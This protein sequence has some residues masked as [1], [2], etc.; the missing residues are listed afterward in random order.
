MK[1]KNT[2]PEKDWQ[3]TH[4][5]I[6]WRELRKRILVMGLTVAMVANTVDLSAL[7][8]SAKTDE[9]ETGKTTIVSF[10]ELSKDITEQTLP[11]GA[12]ESDIKFPTS[13]TVTVEKTTHADE[14]EADDEE[15]ASETGDT[16]KDDAQKD[17]SNGDTASSDDKK[18]TESSDEKDGDS[19]NADASDKSG[20]SD[21]GNADTK[22]SDTSKDSGNSDKSNNPNGSSSSDT[23]D[24]QAR[25]DLPSAFGALIG[26][27][28]D[29]LLPHKLIVYAAEKDDA[30]DT[31]ATSDGADNAKKTDTASTSDNADS[32]KTTGSAD[33]AASSDTETTTEK[34]RL[35]NIKWEL[36]VEE[37]DAE[38]FDS[39]EASNGFCYAYTPVLPDED[40]D[41][42]Q[43]VLGKDL[44]LPTIYVLV[45]EYGI[46]LLAGSGT[47]QITETNADGTKAPYTA[48]DLATWI[49][50]HGSANLEKVSIKLLNDDASITSALTIGTGLAKEIELDLNGHTLTLQGD[51]ARLYFKRANITITSSG[52]NEGTITGNYQYG[53][54]RLKGDG[55]ITVDSVLKIEHVTIKNAGTGSTVAMWGGATC[56]IDEA[57]ISGS[58][59]SQE[60]VITIC[61]SNACTIT[62]T[63]VT[64]NVASGYGA[65]MFMDSCSDCT[66][67]DGAVIKNENSGG[68]CV[69]VNGNYNVKITVEKDA[70]LTA[71]TGSGT[72]MNTSYGKVAVVIEGGTFNGRLFLPD[73]SQITGGTFV[74]ASGCAIEANGSN[75]TLQDLLKV[76]YTLQYEDGTYANLTAK[77]TDK[78]KKVTAVKSP[79]YFT[80]HPTI[81]SGA[82]TVM[83][84]YTAAEAPELTVEA[85]SGSAGSDSISY[86][87]YADETINGTTKNKVEQTGQGA[88]SATYKIPTGLL[89]GT[90]Q[91][92]CVATC[93]EYTAT[94]QKAA[95]TVEE[96]VA[97][98]TVGGNTTRYATLTK[99]FDAVKATVNAADADADLEITLKILKNISET[100]SE[101]KIDGG[102]KNVNFCMDLN[103]CTVTGKGLY[104]IG[105]GVK[106]VFKDAGTGQ[107][108][109]LNAPVSIRNKAKL[110]VENGNYTKNLRFS[111][112]ATGELKGGYYSQSIYIGNANS[113]NTGIS[114]TITG[115][116]YKGSEV[117][118][119]GGA[120][121]SV[122]GADTKIDTLQIDHSKK[123]RAEV[124]L[125]GGEYKIITLVAFPGSNDD[126]LDE[127]QRYAIADT[128]AE[129]Y[130]FYSAGIK[131]DISRT[132]KT[133]NNVKV[134]PAD[135]PED[136]SL[137]VVKFQIEKND[138]KTKTKY[139]LTWD[140]AMSCLE[141]TES[142]LNNLQEYTTWKKL[143]ILLLKDAEAT[144]GYALANKADLPAEIT[145]RSEGNEPH[146]LTGRVNQ[147]FKTGEQD[148][149]IENINVVGNISFPGDTAVLR[150]GGGVAGLKNVM[151]PSGKAEIVIEKGAEIPATF[152]GDDQS[153]LDVSIYCNH[154]S[155]GDIASRIEQGASAF[156]VWF[157][158]E[159][160]GITLPTDG[161]NVTN[162]TQ[163][164]G[165]TYGLY[166]NGG[167]TDQK[168]KVTGEVCS[169]EPYGGNAVT[170][171][172]T[173]LSFTMPSS[174]VTLKAHTKDDH[175]YCS[176]C[177]R[178]DLAEAYKKSRLI[179]EGLEGRIYDGYPQVMTG[180]TLKTA[181]GDVKLTGPKYKSGKELAQDSTG[182]A[183]ADI[184][185]AD[186]TVVY[187][188]NIKCNENKESTDA[189]TAIITGR[190]AYYG[191]VAF[192]F[193]IGQGEMQAA[194]ATAT[195]AE[196]DG[197]AHTA[198]TDSDAINV[199]LKADKYD[200]N[201]H[202]PVTDGYIAP[203]TGKTLAK[204]GFDS[205]YVD[206]FPLKISCKL[207]DGKGYDNA[208]EYTVTNAGSYPFTIM[209]MAEN[210]SCPSVEIPLTAKIT[211]R[212]LSK[213]SIP[214]TPLSGCAY[215]TGK[216]YSFDDLDWEATDLKK[217]LTDSGV[218]GADGGSYVLV[219]D[220]DF[221]VTEEDATGPATGAKPAKLN[222]TG[223]G[224][225]TGNAAIRFEI[226]YA[227]TLAQTLVSGTDKWY[228]ADVPVSFAIDNQND[229]SQILYRNS[230]AA[231]SDSCLNGSVEIYESLEAAVAGENPGYTFTQEGKNTVTLYGK[232]TAK[233]CLS[234]PVEVTICIDK[235]APTWADKDGVADGYGIQIK[236]NW[237]RSLLN[238]I[239][240]GYLYN[241]ATL[242]I[243]IQANDKKADVA[244]VSG[245]SRY[246]Y[247]VEKVSD[248]ALASVKTKDELDALAAGGKFSEAAAG[249][250]T[251]LTSSDGA[252][253]SG[254]LSSEGNYV[255][256]AYAVDGA[257]NQ[258]DYICT[259]GIVVDAQAPVVKIADPKKE[260]GTLKDTEA[261]LKVNLSEDATL[262][263]FFVSEGVF[264]GVTGYTYDDCKRD[265][266]NYMKGE[267]KYPQFAVENDGKW[268]PRN[269]WNFKPDENLYCGQW[270]VRT[271]GLKY[272][273]ANQNFVA[274]WT[275]SIFKTTGTKGDNK[276]EIGN[277][278]KP[279]VYF[280]LY[281]S[282][283]TAVWIAAIDKAGNITALTKPAIEFTTTKTT[284][285]VKTAPVLSGTYGN[286]VS[287]MFAKA[288]MT[289]A[290]VTA[291][292]NSDTKIEGTWTLASEDADKLPTVGTSEK[293]TLVFTPTG[294][295]ADTYDSVTCEVIP[296]VSKKQITVVIADKEKFYGET[297]PALTWSL[298][299]GDAYQD[300]VLVADDTEEALV[301]SLSTTAKDNSDV[302]TYAITGSSDSANYEVSFIGNGS[303]GKSGILTVKQA[304][305]SFTTELS[306]SDYTYAKDE[307]P[308]PNATAKFGTVTYKYATAASDGTAYK[309]PSDASAYTDA[310]PVN[311]GIYAVKAYI[312]ETENYAGLASDPVVFT[313]NKAASPNIGDEEKSYSYV[314][315]S[316]DKAISVD[317]AGKLPTDRGTTAYALTNTYNEQLLSDVAVDQD[318]KL[319]YKVKEADESQVGATA[320]ITVTASMLNY[321]DAVY[322]MTIKITDKKLVTLKSG[323]TVSVNGSNALTYGDKLSKLGFSD[324]TFVEADTDTEVKGTLKWADPDCIPTAGTTQAG[325][326]F[327][328]DDSKYYEDLT[329]TAA[330][331]VARATPAVVTVPTV[332]E[333]VYN[334]AVALADSDMTGGSV[335]GADGNSL[336][337]TWSFTG[338]NIIPTVNNKGYQAV[339]TPDDADNYNTVTRT[340]TV[341]VTKATPVI[342]Q[343][344]TAGAL[345][346]GQKLSDSTLTGGKAAYQTADGTEITGA[347]AWKNSSIK[348]TA[349]DSGKTEYDV[350]F[351]PSDTANYNAVGIK[352][353]LTVNK[354][355][356]APNMPE[357]TMAPAHSTKKVGDITLPDGWNW[358]E[359]DK[360]TALADGVAVTANAIYTG[361]DKGNYETESVSITITRSECDHTHTEIRNQREATCKEKGYTGDT[362]CKDC[363]EKLAAG[364]TIEKKPHK[365]G[366]P[367][368]CV[369][370]AVCSVCSETFG[371]VDATNHVHTTVKNRKEATCTQTGYAGDT[372]CTDCDKLLSTGKELAALGHDYK[373]TVTKQPTTTEEGIRT[374]TCTR[375]NSSYTESIAKLPEEKHTHN[376][377]GSITKEATCTEAGVRTYTCS[378]GNSYT[379]NIPATGHSYVS[380][381]TKAA[382][383]TEEGIMTYTCSKCGHSYT[384]PIAKIKSDDSNKDNGS[385]NQK[386]QSGTDNGNQ[387]QKP[388]PDTDNGKE[389]E[390]SIKPY[391]KDDSGKE[392][393]DVI[394]PQLEEAKSGDTVTVVMNGTTVV[395]K[396]IIDSIKGKDTTL[397]LDMGNG[398]S[399]KIY[400]KDITDAAGDI[401]FDVTVGADAGK[402]IP[403]DVINNVT[404]EHSSL[405]L[406]LAY[407]GEFGF[408]ATLTVNMESKNAGLY[409]NL[410]YYNEQT[411]ELEFI[412]A[413]Q[414]DPDGNVE[415]VFTHASDYTI[416]VDARIMSDNAQADNK[417]DESIPAP[418]TD[419]STSKYAWN[420]TIIIIIGICIIL[421]VFGAVFYVRKK[422]G[423]EEE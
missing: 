80:T 343:K 301:I 376:Y 256:Y 296:E 68:Y 57:N 377:T 367:A 214:P 162:I 289:K 366:T 396:D 304:A 93:G 333:R 79:L 133:L 196:Y 11:I 9:S 331:T 246:Y 404:G 77:Y 20:T 258:S 300:N 285:Y 221:T 124:T 390:D 195:A 270:E 313:I 393:W 399:W 339:F 268:A 166:S 106:A 317:I 69:K 122:S 98:V 292:L 281:P 395:P 88:T 298:A 40:G 163:R 316:D 105:E 29:A 206:K 26:Q 340:I 344:P 63:K 412:S 65:I 361:T 369:S 253:I 332:A 375:C 192:K 353:S 50:G 66:I 348:P 82:E 286:T 70:T 49:G 95:F 150:L 283:K 351:T 108:G 383:T 48:Q 39:S 144:R 309:A 107:N 227:F 237:F 336:A 103:G 67:G 306:C 125:S 161:E 18:D 148:V 299:S 364:T 421:I 4:E 379:E 156:K 5:K 262:M 418:K 238:T 382:T 96:G 419:D 32:V 85:V 200:A 212:D 99:A 356:K 28:A 81:A 405:N 176:N 260:D 181:N 276:I 209:V 55:L 406:T 130:A 60:G 109:T 169:Y 160:G 115:G 345:T 180:I 211:P 84:N 203:C 47:V 415:L 365:V 184:T 229:A 416:V 330:I 165:A 123:L 121:L 139:F 204:D 3:Q 328:P 398:L 14:K 205:E 334:P 387:N 112:G 129:G 17:D 126:L 72:I 302:G 346:Y 114:C 56:T 319:T 385:Q 171:K 44:E 131:T 177:K 409:A 89:A 216:P 315:G 187:E 263:W 8:V 104:I 392:G 373:A 267:P 1:K 355:A 266:E 275:P 182:S 371:E 59:G 58:N 87:W 94:S 154:D 272:S 312:A 197:K 350:T 347:F 308:E 288:D 335:T 6:R 320:T 255:V 159:L 158:I 352:L 338:K 207:A 34:I 142:N 167:T 170:I 101:W 198:L 12:L 178:T 282:K 75:K 273:N 243:K 213:L 411:G 35:K 287:A 76:G 408:T 388:Q 422:S 38:E 368:T 173:D 230:K 378:C 349:A 220:T 140:A 249:T 149:T 22:D 251:I 322:T 294:S 314:A 73:N 248:T 54:N 51:N 337:G 153:N 78:K 117:C 417:S 225:Y 325:W 235:S 36:N 239:S 222:L 143:E 271:E 274:S 175:G 119:Y 342:A 380:K 210:N 202:I 168:I 21:N 307:T 64:G 226:P 90:Y 372:Y 329:G 228:R 189:P 2:M 136:V 394:K 245:I 401:D 208:N 265:I 191:T 391:I 183:N 284:P 43:L 305:N 61:D 326:V 201:A 359:A 33:A 120:A 97:E 293:Y 381:V 155:A 102:T 7:S 110:T 30:S 324:V 134:L 37:S 386:P 250:G 413:G 24:T 244:E 323:N 100:G 414:I 146:T 311:A 172:T 19:G 199:T 25:A 91:Y 111:S 363:G 45:G 400:G 295:D 113:D 354:A 164:D 242:D 360:D 132:E 269:G 157:P 174:K 327:K 186:Y 215:Y 240:F 310:I 193:A 231:A 374:Y 52:S 46:A 92:Y 10:E 291:G 236:E 118:V 247:Y 188:N 16:E 303:D 86:Q 403:V 15:D 410:F 261:I 370:K 223:K 234:E 27:M 137:A 190:G 62:N 219:K 138:G 141:A 407:D 357:T 147:L 423:S 420:N 224:N 42:N 397:V 194:G 53:Q 185:N 402:S 254:S 83:E 218:T 13:L 41:G 264:D 127:E 362:Y 233:G 279:D 232:D 321:E 257:G 297:N 252:T 74:P 23:E 135:T 277:F 145:L 179:I 259:D 280:S 128:L 318:G 116:E 384:Q 358:Q 290:V 389:K 241:D 341:K 151:V 71:N 278:G 31:A 217:L 152:S